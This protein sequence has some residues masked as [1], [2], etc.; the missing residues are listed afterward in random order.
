MQTICEI[1]QSKGGGFE[2][3]RG[4]Y[5]G[6]KQKSI[7]SFGRGLSVGGQIERLHLTGD[8]GQPVND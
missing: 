2:E 4:L 6:S 3:E 5:S 8:E 1:V 7:E